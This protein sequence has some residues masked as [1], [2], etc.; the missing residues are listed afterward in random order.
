MITTLDP[1]VTT[2]IH[3]HFKSAKS[4]KQIPEFTKKI[5]DAVNELYTKG[6]I[7]LSSDGSAFMLED[8]QRFIKK[9]L[10]AEKVDYDNPLSYS[11]S[12]TDNQLYVV[13]RLLN[14]SNEERKK[15]APLAD[16]SNA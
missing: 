1:S 15:T 8:L 13:F 16:K 9:E 10:D 2:A 4:K 5:I 6:V 3:D 14:T 11:K 7:N 12:L